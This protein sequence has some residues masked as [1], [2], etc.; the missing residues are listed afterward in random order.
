[1]FQRARLL[2]VTAVV[3]VAT[4]LALLCAPTVPIVLLLGIR[5]ASPEVALISRVTGTALLSIGVSSWLARND[6]D[7]RAQNGV[8]IGVLIYDII[9]A[10]L[11]AYAALV[12]KLVGV[13]LWPAVV[14]HSALAVWAVASL[15]S[16]RNS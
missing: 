9:V 15:V 8:L 11:L 13:A 7:S 5:T 16:H 1:M 6:R 4:G 3:E 10:I 14:L 2:I 12:L